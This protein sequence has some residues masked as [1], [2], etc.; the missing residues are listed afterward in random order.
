MILDALMRAERGPIW[1]GVREVIDGARSVSALRTIN[2]DLW[3]FVAGLADVDKLELTRTLR[4]RYGADSELQRARQTAERALERGGIR[5]V[6][7]YRAVQSYA[8]A[9]AGD[10]A[11]DAQSL[12]L[13]ALLD[14]FMASPTVASRKPDRP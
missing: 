3:G 5:S 8:D 4:E 6:V 13:G 10:R 2:R 7:E 11:F 1:A 14:D 9:I 12:A